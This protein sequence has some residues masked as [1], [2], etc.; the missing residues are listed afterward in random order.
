MVL[1]YENN[2]GDRHFITLPF[3][4]IWKM[5]EKAWNKEFST[6]EV[7]TATHSV[8]ALD[9][10][11]K[12][13]IVL[14]SGSGVF[15]TSHGS[16][17]HPELRSWK[18]T[19]CTW[20]FVKSVSRSE[21][22]RHVDTQY[23]AVP[24]RNGIYFLRNRQ[25]TLLEWIYTKR[26]RDCEMAIAFRWISPNSIC[27]SYWVV[28]KSKEKFCFCVHFKLVM[29]KVCFPLRVKETSSIL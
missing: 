17:G 25:G 7:S 4:D 14:H 2:T 29:K 1:F 28:A 21:P 8:E 18:W 24:K 15:A 16:C 19:R 26:N 10:E 9:C 23:N 5:S 6:C 13:W 22:A 20:R 3:Y 27:Y 11:Q 12:G